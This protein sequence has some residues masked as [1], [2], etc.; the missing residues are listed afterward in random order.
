MLKLFTYKMA[1]E[2]GREKLKEISDLEVAAKLAGYIKNPIS[3]EV[4]GV[5]MNERG[6]FIRLA[7]E[8]LPTL[9]DQYAR[10]FLQAVINEYS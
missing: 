3:T 2:L 8:Y 9:K 1:E 6:F 5:T 10:D 7:Q 4:D